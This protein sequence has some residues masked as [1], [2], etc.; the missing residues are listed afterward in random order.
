MKYIENGKVAVLVSPGHGA[1]WSTWQ[2]DKY[3]E[4][5]AMDKRLVSMYLD[6]TD[7]DVVVAFCLRTT[8]A[9][10]YMGGWDDIEIEW[11]DAGEKFMIQEYDGHEYLITEEDLYM[12]A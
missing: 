11:L 2:Y 7:E 12:A 10:P 8:G 1:G 9:E 5:Y 4:F 3:K 6:N